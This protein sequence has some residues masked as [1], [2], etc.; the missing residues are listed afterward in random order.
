M[1]RELRCEWEGGNGNQNGTTV[2]SATL[3][4]SFDE[5]CAH[6]RQYVGHEE[7]CCKAGE[8]EEREWRRGNVL[9]G[10]AASLLYF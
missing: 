6:Q 2:L 7:G 10:V 1:C 5:S 8:D 3:I 9:R 4:V